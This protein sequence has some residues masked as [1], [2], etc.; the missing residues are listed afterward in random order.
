MDIDKNNN[1]NS[2]SKSLLSAKDMTLAALFAALTFIM[3]F[4]KIPLPF[5]PVP[6]TGQTFA[7]ML[8]G[9]LLNPVPAFFS[10]LIFVL[11][12][13]V[14]IP[15]FS[16]LNGGL[17]VLIG[18]T[19]GYILSWPIAAFV[20]ASILKNRKPNFIVFLLVNI[21]GAIIIVY[22]FGITQLSFVAGMSIGKAVAAGAI[23]FIPGDLIKA[24]IASYLALKL[25]PVV[26][27]I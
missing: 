12:G 8:S 3:G 24:I 1:S 15:V 10:M 2:T 17:N 4:V 25:K 16:G 27:K 20:M 26:S 18:P 19:G 14:G 11:L 7:V 21:V 5:S 6:I 23:P 9:S 22:I 13:A